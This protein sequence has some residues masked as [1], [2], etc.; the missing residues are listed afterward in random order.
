MGIEGNVSMKVT[1]R[2][3]NVDQAIRVL[4]KK[5]QNEGV[6]NEL[7]KREYYESRGA[8]VRRKKAAGKRRAK[9]A[10]EKRMKELGF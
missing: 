7:R 8:K 9:K 1:V 4:K 6:F 2:N 3:N 10:Q 5:L